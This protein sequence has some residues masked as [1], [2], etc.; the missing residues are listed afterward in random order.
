MMGRKPDFIV[1]NPESPYLLRWYLMPRNRWL[2]VYLHKFLRD[3]DDRALHDHPWPSVSVV[4]S[5]GY[6]EI[7]TGPDNTLERRWYGPRSVR[8]RT[9]RCA[10]RIELARR[11]GQPV[12]CRTLFLT[13]PR[14]REWGFHCPQGWVHWRDFVDVT[15]TGNIGKGCEQ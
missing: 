3:D 4:L 1:G 13:G 2:N 10:H 5:G 9:A 15:N 7:T 14:V 6:Y 12:A 8:F 11:D